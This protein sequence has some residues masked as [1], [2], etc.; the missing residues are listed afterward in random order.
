MRFA[1]LP[2]KRNSLW[3]SFHSAACLLAFLFSSAL[4]ARFSRNLVRSSSAI[5]LTT[6][7]VEA[8]ALSRHSMYW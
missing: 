8:R 2:P 6:V 1:F 5:C 7:L 3:R 4:H